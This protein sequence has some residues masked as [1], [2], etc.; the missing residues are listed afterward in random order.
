MKKTYINAEV[1]REEK[2]RW[3][4]L[5]DTLGF[6]SLSA[7]VRYALAQLEDKHGWTS[8]GPKAQ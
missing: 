4:R 5:T 6:K 1:T 8:G 2:L 3:S 7:L